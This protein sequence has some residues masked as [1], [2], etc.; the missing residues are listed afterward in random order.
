[1]VQLDARSISKVKVI[2]HS[3]WTLKAENVAKMFGTTSFG[4]VIL[5]DLALVLTLD[6]LPT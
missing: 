2:V 5:A 1:M 6:A 4:I 3:Y